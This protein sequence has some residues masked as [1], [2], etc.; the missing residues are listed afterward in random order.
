MT[1]ANTTVYDTDGDFCAALW[2]VD[3]AKFAG[4]I[5][6]PVYAC[7]EISAEFIYGVE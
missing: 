6:R 5:V 4:N 7:G 2:E 3:G 1:M